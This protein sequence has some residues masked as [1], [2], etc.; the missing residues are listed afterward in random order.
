MPEWIGG[1]GC[2]GAVSPLSVDAALS[3]VKT[4]AVVITSPTY[5]GIVSDI[6]GIAEVCHRHGALLIVDAAHGAH[7][8]LS[9]YFLPSAR[10]EG[11][12][13]VIESAHKTLP[14]LTG[15]AMLHVC[16]DRVDLKKIRD[17]F[18]VFV[19]S[20]PSYPILSSISLAVRKLGYN[21]GD[22]LFRLQS[23]R[24]DDL[25]R[26]A[27]VFSSLSLSKAENHD[28]S[29]IIIDCSKSSIYGYELKERLLRD[30][31][32]ECEMATENFVLALSTVCDTA[33][34]FDRLFYALSE[35]DRDIAPLALE[36]ETAAPPQPILKC[37]IRK[38][39]ESECEEL[40]LDRAAGRVSAD[41]VYCYPPG[42]PIIAPGEIIT[43]EA[44]DLVFEIARKG[45]TVWAA[46][47][48]ELIIRVKK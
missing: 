30:Y 5:E 37:A 17:A 10:S 33:L 39:V 23:D 45:G 40:F 26:N 4:D 48:K 41:F 20:S 28:K 12:D 16:S 42:S 1:L 25:Y 19:S 18:S 46:T 34:G 7:L 38:A 44:V 31:K 24:L 47:N 22:A 29:K 8:G 27:A 32:I 2:F 11:A 43:K 13:I 35:I 3:K 15:A 36:N 21:R 9:P 6:S 14:C